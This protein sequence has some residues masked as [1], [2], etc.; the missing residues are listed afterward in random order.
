MLNKGYIR[1]LAGILFISNINANFWQL[2]KEFLT[3]V[4]TEGLKGANTV[5]MHQQI[6]RDIADAKK[7]GHSFS[8][9]PELYDWFNNED[10]VVRYRIK[11]N[12][13]SI[14]KS[15][16][17]MDPVASVDRLKRMNQMFTALTKLIKVP[18]VDI[19]VSLQDNINGDG[20]DIPGIIFGFA[21][22]KHLDKNVILMPDFQILD[23]YPH[24]LKQVEVGNLEYPWEVKKNQAFWIGATTG[25]VY[26]KKNNR[27]YTDDAYTKENYKELDRIK[28][29]DLSMQFPDL[30][31][32][33]LYFLVQMKDD[34]KP[35]LSKYLVPK[36]PIKD[37]MQYKY[38]ISIDGNGAS[39]SRTYWQLFS[40]SVLFK[41]KTDSIRWYHNALVK[42][43][44]YIPFKNDL[45]DLIDQIKWAQG[46]DDKVREIVTDANDFA[47]NHLR[48]ADNLYYLYSLLKEISKI[49]NPS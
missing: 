49:Q 13:L 1:I 37:H 30:L 28:I 5:W 3:K 12:K 7:S 10:L 15:S 8:V 43:K 48:V 27:N 25:G 11:D 42:Y 45:S 40:N 21:K 44:H 33:R 20:S 18:D 6:A 16:K 46:N 14:H 34:L 38:Q 35:L 24:M 41:Q 39:S 22:D 23:I 32:A 4:E 29:C 9:R 2:K 26:S 31:Y 19:I 17:K 36:M 47:L